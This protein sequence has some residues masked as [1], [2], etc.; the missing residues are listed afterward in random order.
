[1]LADVALITRNALPCGG[2]P[3]TKGKR[4]LSIPKFIRGLVCALA[5]W[6]FKRIPREI[7]VDNMRLTAMSELLK[8]CPIPA[9]RQDRLNLPLLRI[10]LFLLF[11]FLHFVTQQ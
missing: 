2:P 6:V 5:F 4:K 11:Y 1:M 7:L 8:A 3:D 9:C 10:F